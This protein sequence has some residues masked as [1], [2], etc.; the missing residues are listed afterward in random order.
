MN[1]QRIEALKAKENYKIGDLIEIMSILREPGGCP[2]DREQNHHTIR[3]NLI[4]ETYEVVEAID[5][6]DM[7]LMQEELG[8]LLLQ[9]VFHARIA[10][11]DDEFDFDDVADGICRKLILR[12]PHIFG[13]VQADT[14][15]QVLTN[16]D[17]IKME[18]KHQK[19][20]REVLDSVSHS[21]PSL[22][23]ADKVGSKAR[24]LGYGDHASDF[25]NASSE[26][27]KIYENMNA[28]KPT[29]TPE[30]VEAAVGKLLFTA[31]QIAHRL[32]VDPEKALGDECDRVVADAKD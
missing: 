11:E 29:E 26:F 6:D 14:T 7:T 22:I 12:H 8:D 27:T 17:N 9:V 23:R 5:K 21:L 32:G 31:V 1:K 24:K 2:W 15:E 19:T 18:E 3:R 30:E 20:D 28:D 13:D 10:E 16:W 4:E 25:E